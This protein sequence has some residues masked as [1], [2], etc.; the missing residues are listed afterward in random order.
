MPGRFLWLARSAGIVLAGAIGIAGFALPRRSPLPALRHAPIHIRRH[1][2]GRLKRGR[3]NEWISNNWAGYELANFQTGQQYT[4]AQMSWVV[5][6]V[7]YGSSAAS[8]SSPQYSANWVGIGGFCENSVCFRADKTLIQL[9]TEQDA[10]PDG[11]TRYYAWYEMLPQVEILLPRV[12]KPGDMMTA[13][14]ACVAAC[15]AKRQVWQL[16]MTD[17]T[18]EWTW[19]R[20]VRY[21]SSMLSAEWIEEA[22]YG[23]GI[24]PLADFAVAGF[25]ATGGTNGQTPPLSTAVNAIQIDDPWGQTANPSPTD[26]LANFSVCWGY[27]SDATCQTP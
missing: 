18:Q 12:V 24:L 13:Q 15:A 21:A 2:D 8:T 19:S 7:R 4:R 25:S 17:P 16:T 22:P 3:R 20:K 14:L 26:T 27:Q 11:A 1:R 10:A 23:N 9:G 5:P 6:S